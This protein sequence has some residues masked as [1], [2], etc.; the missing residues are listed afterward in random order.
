MPGGEVVVGDDLV[1]VAQQPVDQVAADE[2]GPAG[3][4]RLHALTSLF[5][6]PELQGDRGPRFASTVLSSGNSL[7]DL[8][9]LLG[10]LVQENALTR[11]L[12]KPTSSARLL[13]SVEHGGQPFGNGCA[14]QRI[15][16][17]GSAARDL[18]QGRMH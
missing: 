4:E 17:L 3:D 9:S 18:R 8:K 11:S 6:R 2:P 13:G 15:H 1:P 16:Q 7:Q 5:V 14:A 12:P 10:G